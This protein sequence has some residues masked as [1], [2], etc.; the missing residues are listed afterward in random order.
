M[1]TETYCCKII[2]NQRILN[3]FIVIYTRINNKLTRILSLNS[4]DQ[5]KLKL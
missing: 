1:N 4:F 3:F 2:C 5:F